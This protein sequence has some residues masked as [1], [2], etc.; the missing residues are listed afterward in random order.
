MRGQ[1]P[2]S[3]VCRVGHLSKRPPL[4]M[5]LIPQPS[6]RRHFSAAMFWNPSA[7][8]VVNPHLLER[9]IFWRS[10]SLNLAWVG[11]E[12][13][14]PYSALGADGH[15]DLATVPWGFPRAPGLSVWSLDWG[16]HA[17]HECP[18][19]RAAPRFPRAMRTGNRLHTSLRILLF[20]TKVHWPLQGDEHGQLDWLPTF[21]TLNL[22]VHH[23]LFRK[24]HQIVLI[25]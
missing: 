7:L 25:C 9:W 12:S 22:F 6:Q 11:P 18:L 13:P 15:D 17:R 16:Q 14:A 24:S 1:R 8:D 3:P 10:G 5:Y 19:E 2:G 23:I 4:G 21:R 20:G